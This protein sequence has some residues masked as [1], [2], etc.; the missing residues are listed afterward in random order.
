[1]GDDVIEV[2]P[3]EIRVRIVGRL[4]QPGADPL[5]GRRGAQADGPEATARFVELHR[6]GRVRHVCGNP[7]PEVVEAMRAA[8]NLQPDGGRTDDVG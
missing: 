5:A 4:P 8:D 1:M 7:P 3:D 6:A 2:G